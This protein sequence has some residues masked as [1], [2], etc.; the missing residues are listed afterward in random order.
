[1]ESEMAHNLPERNL[2]EQQIYELT[3]LNEKQKKMERKLK[4]QKIK[5]TIELQLSQLRTHLMVQFQNF[6]RVRQELN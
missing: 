6:Q 1:M 3:R 5:L 2:L 4:E